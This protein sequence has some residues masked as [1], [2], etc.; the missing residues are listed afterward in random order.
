MTA[1]RY[2]FAFAMLVEGNLVYANVTH[3][4][5]GDLESGIKKLQGKIVSDMAAEG[6]NIELPVLLSAIQVDTLRPPE[7]VELPLNIRQ[8]LEQIIIDH[9]EGISGPRF[10]YINEIDQWLR[11]IKA[12][13]A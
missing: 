5:E 11:A 4:I 3:S 12:G 7:W 13:A 6:V 10:Q 9:Q 2:I 1:R 8:T